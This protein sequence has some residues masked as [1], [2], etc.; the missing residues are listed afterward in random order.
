M[1]QQVLPETE[2]E[3]VP[4][5]DRVIARAFYISVVV[6]VVI[7]AVVGI[8][9]LISQKEPEKETFVEN[10]VTPLVQE[11]TDTMP[12]VTVTDITQ[13]AGITFTHEN[14]A[15]G[16][17]MLPETM[18][19]GTAF[20][21]FDND[22]NPDLLF[23]NSTTWPEDEAPETPPTMAL[24]ENDGT[25]KFSDVTKARG[26]DVTLYGMGVACGDYDR[27]GDVD[28]FVSAVGANKL[29]RNDGARFVDVTANAG[30]AGAADTWSTSAAFFDADRDGDLDLFVC[31]Y[32]E[33]SRSINLKLVYNLTGIGR[34]YGPPTHFKGTQCYFYTNRGDGTFEDT[35]AASG[36]EVNN[37]ATGEPVAKALGIAPVDAN[38]DGWIDLL[39]ANDTVR[40]FFFENQKDGTFS[41]TGDIAG[42]A[43]DRNGFATGAMGVD[44]SLYRNDESL[45]FGVGNFANE[46]TSLYAS[47][48]GFFSD[49][50]ITEGIG[51]ES[52]AMLTFGLFFFDYDL[53]GRAD[54]FQANGHLEEEINKV[55]P[56]QHYEQPAQLF[57]NAGND[58]PH[59]YVPVDGTKAGDLSKPLVGRGAAYADIDTDGDLDVLITQVGAPPT[60]LRNDQKLGNHWLR[61][62]LRGKRSNTEGVGAWIE[63][64]H[65]DNKQRRQIM[66]TCSYLSQVEP[67]V[68]FGLGSSQKIDALRVIWPG[69]AVQKVD[70]AEIDRVVVV[71]EAP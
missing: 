25:G 53:D 5:D 66:P 35:S 65:G 17:K 60:L 49:A 37:I 42:V 28:I 31:N 55:Q 59:T 71:E 70:N 45:A 46:M 30:V 15:R 19:G 7:A 63:V 34:A 43:F 67:A 13:A 61:V 3:Q 52:R 20:L 68:T 47:D 9:F 27:D 64:E 10:T 8:I 14:G 69:G 48:E 57:W 23:I 33:W 50:A 11:R 26:L 39:I 40:N 21:D 32:V 38:G 29:F 44:S 16:D 2:G 1:S 6:I 54:L 62:R 58:A 36:I 56:S 41:E 24:Y 4:Q 18:G 51:P 12:D 22:G